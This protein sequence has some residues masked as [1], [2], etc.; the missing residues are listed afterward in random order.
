VEGIYLVQ[1]VD[2]LGSMHVRVYI[3]KVCTIPS[4]LVQE[5]KIKVKFN[6]EQAT[7]VYRESRS[8]AILFL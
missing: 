4:D 5:L 3:F 8:I 6:L 1:N 7:K 2:V